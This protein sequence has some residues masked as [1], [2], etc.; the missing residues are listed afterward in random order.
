MRGRGYRRLKMTKK[1]KLS[2]G[3]LIVMGC[4]YIGVQL[5]T[6]VEAPSSLPST[7]ARTSDVANPSRQTASTTVP[8]SAGVKVSIDPKTNQFQKPSAN[9]TPGEASENVP[10]L[11]AAFE[12]QPFLPELQEKPSPIVGGGVITNVR[13]RFRRPLMAT[14]DADG[15]LTI[16]HAPQA[17]DLN[18][19]Q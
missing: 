5:W 14:K 18:G 8:S 1:W 10:S 15:K 11:E 3:A 19:E 4:S 6:P 12:P 16:Q 17:A 7:P 9:V 13:L 2:L